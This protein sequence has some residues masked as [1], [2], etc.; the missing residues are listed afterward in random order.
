MKDLATY[1]YCRPDCI[2]E[3]LHLYV[4]ACKE[5]YGFALFDASS[6][7]LVH[8]GAGA[9][10]TQS[11]TSSGQAEIWGLHK[12]LDDCRCFLMGRD[13]TVFT[14]AMVVRQANDQSNTSLLIQRQLDVL[15]LVAG[16]LIHIDDV[17]N[18]IADLLSRSQY[19]RS[20]CQSQLIASD[21][22]MKLCPE[23]HLFPNWYKA[24]RELS[25]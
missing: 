25:E 24:M 13:F 8:M 7:R 23:T 19:W 18:V 10:C 21:R 11:F 16:K 20:Q 6:K 5:G 17:S 4:D 1:W 3:I 9:F 14:D 22:A 2:G 15:N 12:A